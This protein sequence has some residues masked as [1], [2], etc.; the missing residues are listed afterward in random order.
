VRSTGE[1][2]AVKI[3]SSLASAPAGTPAASRQEA[4]GGS[5]GASHGL[6]VAGWIT[7]SVLG[8][9]AVASAIVAASESASLKSARKQYPADQA[10]IDS[11]SST[12]LTTSIPADSL[13]GAAVVLGALTL[14]FQ[15]TKPSSTASTSA[16][17]GVA[18][19]HVLF[20]GTF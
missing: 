3:V 6:L 16:R 10:S 2:R 19:D 11:K 13:G 17:V 12:T 8:A 18:A 1:T 15:V 20:E 5:S 9:G 4:Q 14:Y 7:T